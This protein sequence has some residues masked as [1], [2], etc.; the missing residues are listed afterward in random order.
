MDGRDIGSVVLKDAEL[1][2]YQVAELE[3]RADRRYKENLEKGI[4]SDYNT[5]LENLKQR[6]YTDIN[7]S[8]ALVKCEDAIEL[9]TTNMTIEEVVDCIIKLVKEREK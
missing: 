7:V 9:D 2:I 4:N 5:I 8:K 3:T 6:D 1:K